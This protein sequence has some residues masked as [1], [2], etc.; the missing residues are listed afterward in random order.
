M[1][2]S[3]LRKTR[4][5][6]MS[7]APTVI[8]RLPANFK[9]SFMVLSGFIERVDQAEDDA[10]RRQAAIGLW[11]RRWSLIAAL[12]SPT[13]ENRLSSRSMT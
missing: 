7:V 4:L 1:P 9:M 10:C 13:V 2:V 5:M 8:V 11:E 6:T 3:K 12:S